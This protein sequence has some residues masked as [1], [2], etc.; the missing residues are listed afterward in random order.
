MQ[1][2]RNWKMEDGKWGAGS[3][4]LSG[5]FQI[6][7][8]EFPV[9]NFQFRFSNFHFP[10]SSLLR[11]ARGW[12]AGAAILALVLMGPTAAHAQGCAM[13][14]TS[15]A[16]AKAGA[17]QALR[18]GI[19]I[20][21]LPPLVMMGIIAGVIY[22]YR[23]RFSGSPDWTIEHDRELAQMLAHTESLNGVVSDTHHA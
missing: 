5:K 6:P 3:A 1:P 16:A 21:L 9:S 20:L 18:S 4:F 14:Y 22:R 11:R 12:L 8:N 2:K 19:L 15:A 23:N 10:I 7:S 17:L 13:C